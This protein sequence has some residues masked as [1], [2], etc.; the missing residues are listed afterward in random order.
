[1]MTITTR[2]EDFELWA[3]Y[4]GFPTMKDE[5]GEYAYQVTQQRYKLWCDCWR[6]AQQ[7]LLI[8]LKSRGI[9]VPSF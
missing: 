7:R 4:K 2:Q 8:D 6:T 1:M 9:D 3:Y 5:N